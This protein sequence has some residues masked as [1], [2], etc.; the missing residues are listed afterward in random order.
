MLQWTEESVITFINLYKEKHCLW[1]RKYG[2]DNTIRIRN[3]AWTWIVRKLSKMYKQ[4]VTAL[5]CKQK[6][7]CL[8]GKWRREK[9]KIDTA[10]GEGAKSDWPLYGPLSFL[11]NA[12]YD[13]W[14]TKVVMPM[15]R[16][17][18]KTKKNQGFA[19]SAINMAPDS[20]CGKSITATRIIATKKAVER[21][22]NSYVTRKSV[23]Q[24]TIDGETEDVTIPEENTET[25]AI[26]RTAKRPKIVNVNI[27]HKRTPEIHNSATTPGNTPLDL[28]QTPA[29]D[30][31]QS[32]GT[33]VA[34]KLRKYSSCA[35][36]AVEHAISD[37]LYNADIGC[38]DRLN[39][40]SAVT[41]QTETPP[42]IVQECPETMELYELV[43][44][45]EISDLDDDCIQHAEVQRR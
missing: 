8:L 18:K 30:E 39:S 24:N 42:V 14:K 36:N 6:I 12:A 20:T 35:R 33:F 22:R 25:P 23:E 37:I 17:R 43:K 19:R 31:C 16:T 41:T 26:K 40:S 10:R 4:K 21:P 7:K 9:M 13:L 5:E 1:D 45:E 27:I 2:E 38:Y 32:F 3:A 28:C 15:S 11:E 44:S 29:Q 34:N